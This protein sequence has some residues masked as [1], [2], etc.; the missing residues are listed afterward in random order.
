MSNSKKRFSQEK[1]EAAA[2]FRKSETDTGSPEVQVAILTRR[3]ENLNRHFEHHK[4]D[5]HS[6]R[7]LLRIVS[8][9]KRLLGYLRNEDI[10]RYRALISE[11]GLR[12]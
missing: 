12:K 5:K 9:R 11:L 6:R 4:L 2:K 3:L 10:G 8:K 1:A 7:G